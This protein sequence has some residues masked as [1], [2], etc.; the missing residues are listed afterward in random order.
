MGSTTELRCANLPRTLQ[1]FWILMSWAPTLPLKGDTA[2][3]KF[4][5]YPFTNGA[6]DGLA[7]SRMDGSNVGSGEFCDGSGPDGGAIRWP[8]GYA[9]HYI[10][11]HDVVPT[12]R[13]FEYVAWRSSGESADWLDASINESV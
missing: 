8:E 5:G 10:G 13:F 12:R 1:R 7:P 3:A 4:S 6:M 2:S 11:E 9:R